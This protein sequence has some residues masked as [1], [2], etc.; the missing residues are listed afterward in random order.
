[1]TKPTWVFVAGTYRTG[2]TTQYRITRDIVEMTGQG[3]GIGYHTENK[4]REHDADGGY[5]VC[6]VFE[7]LPD[8]FRGETSH[9][10]IIH[11]QNRLKA[12]VSVRHPGDI[13][14][15][16]RKRSEGRATDGGPGEWDFKETAT[17]KFPI[18]LGQSLKW[19]DLGEDVTY[20]SRFEDFTR[21]LLTETRNIAAHLGIELTD[22]QAKVIAGRYTVK[23]QIQ[24][25]EEHRKAGPQARQ[26]PWLPS[27][28]GIVFGTSGQYQTWLNG[29]EQRMVYEA[30]AE[31]YKRFGYA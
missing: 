9:G 3:V 15:S 27:V 10:E 1:M 13:I 7:F 8:G 31:Y 30:N 24:A 29:P 23:A 11:R 16:M 6:K 20:V 25:Q 12:V 5:I 18:W 26:D 14:T 17:V 2:S 4:L 19:I 21:N 28:P 22:D